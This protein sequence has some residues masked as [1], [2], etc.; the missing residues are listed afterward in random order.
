MKKRLLSLALA[1]VMLVGAGGVLATSGVV[2]KSLTYRDISVSVD[3]EKIALTDVNGTAVEPFAI[4]GTTYVPVRA[5]SENLG[6]NV[7]WNQTTGEISLTAKPTMVVGTFNIDVKSPEN[8][9][10]DQRDLLAGYGVEIFGVQEVDVGLPRYDVAQYDPFTDFTAATYKDSFFGMS[11]SKSKDGSGGYGNGIVSA[12]E[13]KNTSVTELYGAAQ[14]PKELQEEIY[15]VYSD[16][17]A[18]SGDWYGRMGALWSADGAMAKGGIEPRSYS[19]AVI[20]KDGIE[21]AFYS[22]HLTVEDPAVRTEQ[23]KELRAALDAD[24]VEYKI[25]VGDFNADQGTHEYDIFTEGGYKLAN[26]NRGVWFNTIGEEEA[27]RDGL[28][29]ETATCYVD[30]IIVSG[31]I[32]IDFVQMVQTELSDHNPLIAGI[33]FN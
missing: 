8:L 15:S 23:L 31:N 29:I 18:T 2:Q 25:M 20:E 12:Y 28:G 5:V 16:W 9:V 3:G 14:A 4:D 21:I 30:N 32:T 11:I 19:R 10:T 13:L 17:D 7:D 24:P 27:A 33:T 22:L 1:V 6:Y 26:G